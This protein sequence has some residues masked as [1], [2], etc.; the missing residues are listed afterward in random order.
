M[1]AWVMTDTG[2]PDVLALQEVAMPQPGE[3]EVLIRVRASG[4]NPIDTKIRAGLALIAPASGILGCDVCGDIEAVGPG[5]SGFKEGDRV[6]GMTGGVRGT[7]G[8]LAQYQVADAR[9]LALA[10]ASLT[11]E[12]A[13]AMPLVTL[14]AAQA[15]QRL[16]LKT[17]DEVYICGASGGVGQMALQLAVAEGCRVTGS[18]G[19]AERVTHI[20]ALGGQGILHSQAADLVAE[21]RTFSN[22][23]DTFGGESLQMALQLAA[24]YGQ[25]A[26]INARAQYDLAQAHAKALTLHA[27]FVLLPLLNGQGRDAFGKRLQA[28][29]EQLDNGRLQPLATEAF[30]STQLPEVHRRYEAEGADR[31]LVIKADY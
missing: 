13:A 27:V 20:E 25:V 21:G 19:S 26:T 8:T 12:Q 16:D 29:A 31:K 2:S 11:D 14:T 15:L 24:P 5:V 7:Q 18:A 17:G 10:P 30:S 6:Y 3:G 4:F 23:L 28:V 9:L 22:L 1:K